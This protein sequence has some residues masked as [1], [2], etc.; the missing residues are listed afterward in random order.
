MP[1]N[2]LTPTTADI[3]PEKFRE[4]LIFAKSPAAIA[5]IMVVLIT[6]AFGLRVSDL[7]AESLGEDELNKL[8]TVEEYRTNG[9]SGKNGEHPFLMKGLQTL[10]I[11]GAEKLN[12]LALSPRSQ[13]ST[14]AALR[15]PIALFGTFTTLLLFLLVSRLFGRSIG[16]VTAALWAFE[17]MAIGFDRVAKED[18]LVLFF[19]LLTLLFWVR[20]QTQAELGN[21][22]WRWNAYAAGIAFAGLMASKYYPFLL[23][24]P[25]AY[26]NVFRD[27]PVRRWD[28][29]KKGWV[30]FLTLM[31][32]AFLILNPTIMMPDTWGEMLKFSSENRIGHD[33]YEFMGEF[34]RNQMSA[35]L[36]GVPWTFYFVFIGV[37]TSFVTLVLFLIG[38]PIM[39]LRRLG[40]GRFL[41]LL[42]AVVWLASYTFVGGK[43]TRYFTSAAPLVMIVA[44]VAFCFILQN[45]SDRLADKRLVF[46]MQVVLFAG[47][48]SAPLINAHLAAPNFRLF[49]NTFGMAGPGN[50]FPHDEFYD[51]STREIVAS[52][53]TTARPNAV[54][55]C[56][57]PA[58]FA[59]YAR[60]AGR[61]DL[62]IVSLS[63]RTKV[64]GLGEGDVVVAAM[65]RRYLS[66]SGYLKFLERSSLTS[67]ETRAGDVVTARIYWLD[68]LTATGL[69][70]IQSR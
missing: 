58:L 11:V 65:G 10:S 61:G 23:A 66:N 68:Q 44:A 20:G 6:V 40:D 24:V 70:A 37:K 50:Y 15:F 4:A 22:R 41:I 42:W 38:L 47:F 60:L 39:V 64:E 33:S 19:L 59:H 28:M 32:I 12:S 14:E 52:I 69:K 29:G 67:V 56:E 63:D 43:F 26:Y 27:L 35:W 48:V 54:V 57:T 1:A 46:V 16:L 21:R 2:I 34:Y 51:L 36:A 62:V 53:S 3:H 49:T 13:I 45:L 5:M 30:I 25:T 17:P 18:S 9:L 31:G 7:S 55:A 8:Q